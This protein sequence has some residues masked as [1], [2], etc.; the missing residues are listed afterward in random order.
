MN[1]YAKAGVGGSSR[2]NGSSS[3]AIN[4]GSLSSMAVDEHLR[5]RRNSFEP[6]MLM[7]SAMQTALQNSASYQQ[8]FASNGSAGGVGN[9][10]SSHNPYGSNTSTRTSSPITTTSPGPSSY[11][12]MYG[13][14]AAFA[15]SS[16][17]GSS[18][19]QQQ[20]QRQ[21]QSN[22]NNNSSTEPPFFGAPLA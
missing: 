10:S 20:Q 3:G 5:F 15:S 7:P 12:S 11:Q 8:H 9:T 13:I 4:T 17:D 2:L 1:P 19:S 16:G 18:V 22:S 6:Q 14:G 21:Q